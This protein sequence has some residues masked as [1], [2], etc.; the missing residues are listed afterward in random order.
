MPLIFAKFH[1]KFLGSF[2]SKGT[3]NMLRIK[4]K[5][6]FAKNSSNFLVPITVRIKV[7]Y[8]SSESFCAS[9][10]IKKTKTKS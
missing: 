5:I 8:N 6:F 10:L 7:D 1:D 4:E 3:F 9:S 2:V